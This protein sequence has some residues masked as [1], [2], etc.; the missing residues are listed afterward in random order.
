MT[1]SNVI[2]GSN[3]LLCKAESPWLDAEFVAQ[4]QDYALLKEFDRKKKQGENRITK[5]SDAQQKILS[6]ELRCTYAKNDPCWGYVD[7]IKKVISKCINGDCHRIYQC[8]PAFTIEY[9]QQW[10]PSEEQS[11]LYKDPKK[12]RK[13]YFVDMISDEEMATYYSVPKNEGPEYPVLKDPWQVH[14]TFGNKTK[15]DPETGKRMVIV[16]YQWKISDNGN[17]E[18]EEMIPIWNY[19]E[20]IVTEKKAF[21]FKKAKRIEKIDAPADT[22]HL[23]K[24][25][26]YEESVKE[27][28]VDELRLTDITNEITDSIS[29]VM[30]F[31]NPAELAYVS[32]TFLTN[33]VDH[34]I[35][36][37]QNTALALVEDYEKYAD[38]E[39]VFISNFVLKAGCNDSSVNAW[40]KLSERKG[41]MLLNVSNRDFRKFVYDNTE[42]WTCGNLYGVT[43]VN[44]MPEDFNLVEF[45]EEGHYNIRVL[46]EDNNYVMLDETER[47]IGTVTES[48]YDFMS[49]LEEDNEIPG[50][51]MKI[52]RLAI[53][54][55]NGIEDVLGMGHLK[56]REY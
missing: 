55:G 45:L 16:G 51:P 9:A 41:L 26:Y 12:L 52:E 15:I 47:R 50:M 13:Y 3:V 34:G 48:F 44:M 18:A 54:V 14:K 39:I 40:R 11:L 28:I 42:R 32:S 20:E 38:K 21:E 4:I 27:N 35:L 2:T 7:D 1:M 5:F 25:D 17:Y 8:N 30:L 43:H 22:E 6:T 23:K 37:N 10:K 33:G 46:K 49:Y 19:V 56:F 53:I 24:K 31:D 36:S 29:S